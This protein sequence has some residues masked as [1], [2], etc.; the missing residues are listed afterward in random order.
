MSRP[1]RNTKNLKNSSKTSPSARNRK[2]RPVKGGLRGPKTEKREGGRT[3][4]WLWGTHA[5][6]AALGNARRTS[7]ELRASPRALQKLPA[8][9]TQKHSHLKIIETE[10]SAL[11]QFLPTGTAHQGLALRASAPPSTPLNELA[12]HAEGT[13]LV[14]DQVTDPQNVGAMFRLAK[15][16]G[17]SG[18][19]MQDRYAPP[20]SG[21][22]AKVS[23]GTLES[24]PFA[25]VTN[26]ANSLNE[27]KDMGWMVTGLAGESELTLSQAFT[28]PKNATAKANVIVM[29]AEGPGLRL[30]VR[31][32][33]DQLAKIEM[34]GGAESLNVSTA[35]AI[36]IY[37]AVKLD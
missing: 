2:A 36:A 11:D 19:I 26:I 15:A 4:D 10:P 29:G 18:I 35:A 1:T 31:G 12:S 23:V 34:P 30:R 27:L 37:E 17:L 20:L 13:L 6:I 21:A 9:L 14:L 5:V 16:F 22:T 32:C 28:L 25:L 8:G 33:C 24:V 3:K 7:F